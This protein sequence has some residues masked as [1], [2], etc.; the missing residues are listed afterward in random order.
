MRRLGGDVL[1]LV[2][3]AAHVEEL[4]G[5]DG[6]C[7]SRARLARRAADSACILSHSCMIALWLR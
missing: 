6:W 4:F 7:A 2:R 1:D 3:I 5:A